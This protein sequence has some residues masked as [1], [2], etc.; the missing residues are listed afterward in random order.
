M[1]SKVYVASLSKL[2]STFHYERKNV[3]KIKWPA[4]FELLHCGSASHHIFG[5]EPNTELNSNI[6]VSMNQ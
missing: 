6:Q 5:Y 4:L 1:C 3:S 2:F